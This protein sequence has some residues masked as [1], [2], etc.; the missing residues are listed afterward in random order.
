MRLMPLMWV[1]AGQT[2][3]VE[4]GVRGDVSMQLAADNFRRS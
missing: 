2:Y 3:L 1:P 4:R